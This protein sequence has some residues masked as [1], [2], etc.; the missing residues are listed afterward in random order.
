ML[1]TAMDLVMTQLRGVG[2][3]WVVLL[4][5]LVSMVLLMYG[6]GGDSQGSGVL[7]WGWWTVVKL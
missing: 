2:L 3:C 6:S 1:A 4:L 7:V 5:Q